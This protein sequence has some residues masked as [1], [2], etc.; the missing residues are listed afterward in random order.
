LIND[1][2]IYNQAEAGV[3]SFSDDMEA[4]KHNFLL[5]GFFKNRGFEDSDQLAKYATPHLPAGS[6][7]QTFTY[8]PRGIFTK[9]DSAK[10]KNSKRLNAAGQFLENQ[11]FGLAVIAVSMGTKGDTDEDRELSEARADAVRS[12]LVQNYRLDDTRL[13][14]IGMGKTVQ[15]TEEGSVQ[16]R[17]YADGPDKTA[18]R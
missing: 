9:S 4:L 1:R 8:D 14:I 6:P 7:I 2:S 10:L 5:R 11:K 3:T 17:V 18:V 12:Y 13:K 15:G 16:V